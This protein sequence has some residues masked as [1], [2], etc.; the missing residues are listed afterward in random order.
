MHGICAAP[1]GRA[2]RRC[3]GIGYV[4]VL[5]CLAVTA[6]LATMATPGL[7]SAWLRAHRADAIGALARMQLDQERFHL[8]RGRYAVDIVELRGAVGAGAA[9][10][11]YALRVASAA[12]DEYLAEAEATGAQ[13]ADR[14]DCRRLAV[15]QL[16]E[17]SPPAASGCWR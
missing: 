7:R 17:R 9:P 6:M 5:A 14:A 13:S 1:A 2:A 15:N 3:R 11:H 10:E 12:P 8:E 16:G 4:E